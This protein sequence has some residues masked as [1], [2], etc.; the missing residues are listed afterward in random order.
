MELENVLHTTPSTFAFRL[1]FTTAKLLLS[2]RPPLPRLEEVNVSSSLPGSQ[3]SWG[4][5]SA[6]L[7][8]RF[9]TQD[10]TSSFL[11]ITLRV[12]RF[13]AALFIW[14]CFFFV[15]AST[16]H[17]KIVVLIDGRQAKRDLMNSWDSYIS[18][19]L[20]F[21]RMLWSRD[22]EETGRTKHFKLK[23]VVEDY[24]RCVLCG[25]D[26]NF[27]LIFLYLVAFSRSS[28]ADNLFPSVWSDWNHQIHSAFEASTDV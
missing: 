2:T 9:L 27:L 8:E 21:C 18:E 5:R 3:W 16:Q 7:L 1:N 20:G 22:T 12:L 28:K 23:L 10:I 19:Q 14:S 6:C 13:S 26:W 4:A 25:N 24:A 15:L 17:G 11:A